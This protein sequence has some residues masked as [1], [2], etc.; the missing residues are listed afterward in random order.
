MPLRS[1]RTSSRTTVSTAP[2]TRSNVS[3]ASFA[4]RSN[5][6]QWESFSPAKPSKDFAR[7]GPSVSA[8]QSVPHVVQ[9]RKSEHFYQK[10]A[11]RPS[12][13]RRRGAALRLLDHHNQSIQ[14]GGKRVSTKKWG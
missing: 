12:A 11:S 9:F 10:R 1:G 2:T 6:K 3:F 4:A 5:P 7:I 8:G 13:K 14:S